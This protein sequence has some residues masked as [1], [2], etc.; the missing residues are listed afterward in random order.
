MKLRTCLR[1]P[2]PEIFEA[3]ALLD[4]A[5]Q[6]HLARDHALAAKLLVQANMPAIRD[7]TES[8]WGASSPHVKVTIEA[9]STKI[10]RAERVP[11][12]MPGLAMTR[13]LHERDGYHC[14]FCGVPLV[15]REVRKRLCDLY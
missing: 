13:A 10:P 11:K 3:A 2:V 4:A 8:L 7:W 5:I 1:E 6:A 15:R 12:R 9:S 14:R